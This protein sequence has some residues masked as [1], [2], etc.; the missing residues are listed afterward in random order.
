MKRGF[1]TYSNAS[2]HE[3]A[4]RA[5]KPRWINMARFSPQTA[6]EMAA[7]A[8]NR[9]RAHI[10]VAITGIAGP[11]GGTA[12]KTGRDGMLRLDAQKTAWRG[13][14]THYFHGK[15]RSHPRSGGLSSH[16]KAS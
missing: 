6:T 1:I 12:G 14:K 15:S 13:K 4:R 9:S 5:T 11:D 16:C 7:G 3:N 2:K 8:L 10:S